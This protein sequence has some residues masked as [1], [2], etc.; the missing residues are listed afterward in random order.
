[1]TRPAHGVTSD[2]ARTDATRLL[3]LP[4]NLP[5]A[6]L[7]WGRQPPRP[8]RLVRCPGTLRPLAARPQG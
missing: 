5:G 8:L 4:G 7:A 6:R 1:M 3:L 2:P